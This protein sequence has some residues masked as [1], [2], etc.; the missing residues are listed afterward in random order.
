MGPAGDQEIQID[1]EFLLVEGIVRVSKGKCQEMPGKQVP[2]ETECP[3]E[4]ENQA[5]NDHFF[6]DDVKPLE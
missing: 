4:N 2:T 6:H 1:R 3:K 5:L